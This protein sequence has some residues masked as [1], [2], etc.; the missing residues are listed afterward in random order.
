MKAIFLISFFALAGCSSLPESAPR[1][2]DAAGAAGR[3]IASARESNAAARQAAASVRDE[4]AKA[5]TSAEAISR[6]ADRL[7]GKE[8]TP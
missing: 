4:V 7:I 3:Q 1:P 6:L 5:Q 2:A 8:P